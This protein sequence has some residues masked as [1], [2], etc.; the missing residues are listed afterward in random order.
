VKRALLAAL[1]VAAFVYAALSVTPSELAA[2]PRD[3][4]ALFLPVVLAP[5]KAL[6][7]SASCPSGGEQI[8]LDFCYSYFPHDTVDDTRPYQVVPLIRGADSPPF[9]MGASGYVMVLNEPSNPNLNAGDGLTPQQG[10]AQFWNVANTLPD[11][12]LICCN[13]YG[14]TNWTNAF[15]TACNCLSRITGIS[16]HNYVT[17]DSPATLDGWIGRMQAWVSWINSKNGAYPTRH[18][19][20]WCTECAWNP[21]CEPDSA[22]ALSHMQALCG[23]IRTMGLTR[24]AWYIGVF[25]AGNISLFNQDS[26]ESVLGKAYEAC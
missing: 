1:A 2:K 17:L 16:F 5:A 10:A 18:L 7:G 23:V 14:D 20:I 6:R 25:Q 15:L 24:F 21:C 9:R 13:D 4:F 11:A 26:S 8:G 3:T 12:K 22:T 19:E